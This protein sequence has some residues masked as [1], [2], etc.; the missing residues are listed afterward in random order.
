M[1]LLLRDRHCIL[2]EEFIRVKPVEKVFIA[3][4][5]LKPELRLFTALVDELIMAE[6]ET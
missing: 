5:G 4:L 3:L 2:V 1:T 6:L